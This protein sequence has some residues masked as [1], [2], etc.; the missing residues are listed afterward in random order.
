MSVS[1]VRASQE[2]VGA[3]SIFAKNS[4]ERADLFVTLARSVH[5]Q[6]FP[7]HQYIPIVR[8]VVV[9]LE[10]YE[11][12]RHD[13]QP[14]HTHSHFHVVLHTQ[15]LLC[16]VTHATAPVLGCL[17]MYAT[18]HVVHGAQATNTHFFQSQMPCCHGLNA[19]HC[20]MTQAPFKHC[21][22]SSDSDIK[23]L[24]QILLGGG[25]TI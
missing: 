7:R 24:L 4:H 15:P 1:T 3:L 17:G 21:C 6:D 5:V 20:C 8:L 2:V 14:G 16:C 13:V 18:V 25:A 12:Y 23:G 22:L 9:S 10:I 11:L 19:R